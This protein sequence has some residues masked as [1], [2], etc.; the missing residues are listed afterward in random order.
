MYPLQAMSYRLETRN[1]RFVLFCCDHNLHKSNAHIRI[2]I[3]CTRKQKWV[4]SISHREW[5]WGLDNS[6]TP[7]F[8]SSYSAAQECWSHQWSSASYQQESK[9]QTC[10]TSIKLCEDQINYSVVFRIP[11]QIQMYNAQSVHL[12]R[13]P[14]FATSIIDFLIIFL[15][16]ISLSTKNA[17]LM[18]TRSKSLEVPN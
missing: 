14:V 5:D 17:S 9:L 4:I 12:H 15:L 2:Q 3:V 6:S 16:I 10:E 7:H 1:L 13:F 11:P 18:I 8:P